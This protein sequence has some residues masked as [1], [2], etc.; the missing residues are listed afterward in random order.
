MKRF[1]IGILIFLIPLFPV[2]SQEVEIFGY[3]E[4]QYIGIYKDDNYYQINS[5]KL[6]VD[7]KSK[8]LENTEI[9]AN[10]IYLLNFGKKRYK[11]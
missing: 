3:Y 10:V 8:A 7:I 9:G 11:K 2:F 5:N 1:N 4:P 6:R